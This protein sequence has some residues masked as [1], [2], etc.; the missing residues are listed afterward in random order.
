M[1]ADAPTTDWDVAQTGQPS[2]TVEFT[3]SEATWTTVTVSPDGDSVV[4]DLLGDLYAVP[5]SGGTAELVLGGPAM[6]KMPIFG[7]DRR[8][9]FLSDADGHDNAWACDTDGGNLRQ[10]TREADQGILTEPVWGP[11]GSLVAGRIFPQHRKLFASQIRL[12]EVD[13]GDDGE[14]RVLVDV[15]SSGRDVLE[16]TVSRDGRYVYYTERLTTPRIYVD[17][18]HTN[19]AIRRL[20]LAEGRTDTVVGGFGGAIRPVPSPD[21]RSLAF[22][23]RVKARTVLFRLDLTTGEQRPVFDDLDRD[24][25]AVWE[26]QGNYFPRFSWFPDSRTVAIWCRGGIARIDMHS[27]EKTP[28]PFTARCRHTV[29]DPV[30]PRHELAPAKVHARALRH[31]AFGPGGR[32]AVFVAL[33]RLWHTRLDGGRPRPVGDHGR[34]AA[35]PAYHPDGSEVAYVEWDDERGSRLCRVRAGEWNDISEVTETTAVIRQPAFSPDGRTLAYRIQPHDAHLGGAGLRPGIYLVDLDGGSPTYLSDADDAPVFGPDG[36][37]VYA[38]TTE[39]S[40]DEPS[41]VLFSVDRHGKDRREHARTSSVD[42]Y[43]LRLSPDGRWL[44]FRDQH[45]YHLVPY[46]ETGRPLT[47]SGS[48]TEVPGTLL[49]EHG[50]HGL[51]WSPDGRSLHWAVG[52]RLF[53]LA[54][55]ADGPVDPAA[56]R[57]DEVELTV[58]A[59]APNGRIALVGGRVIS[60]RG[61]EVI[62]RGTV[63]VEN[64]RIAAVGPMHDIAVPADATV[65]D[66]TGK[67]VMPGLVDGHGHIDGAVEDA[68]TPQKQAN[69]YAALAFG[70]TTNFDPFSSELPTFESAET[71]QA[72]LTRG[73]RWIATGSAVHGRPHNFFHLYTPIESYEDALRVVRNKAAL[74]ALSIK[75]YKWPARKHRQMLVKAAREVGV[76]IVVEGETHFYNNISMILDGHT[77]LEHNL[78][79]ATLYDDVVQ[80]MAAAEV[81]NTP[82][83]VVA[84]G[85]LFGENWAYQRGEV[86]K[87][88]RV[89]TY[90]QACLSGYSPLNTPYEAPPHARAMTTIHVDEEIYDIG[91]LSV[92]RSVCRLDE[93]G[94][95]INAGSHGQ[96]PGMAMH[97][98][99]ALLAEGGMPPHRVLRAATANTAES[100]GVGDQIGSLEAGKLADLIVLDANPLEDIRNSA[101]VVMAMVNGRLLDAQTL[102]EIA[103]DPKPRTRFMW[104]LQDT[105]G[106]DWAEPW[107]GGCGCCP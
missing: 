46:R 35:E 97:W 37:R 66:C 81:S 22:L 16:A 90:I 12:Y 106:I 6:H 24:N 77:N 9:L 1:S 14:G 25:Q 30:R 85:E 58:P 36:D 99:M 60:L 3:T 56:A 93:A 49:M 101:R 62:E 88:P 86:W 15:P 92:S 29:V 68:V 103:P 32:E 2:R 34:H 96:M 53:S 76:N 71:T 47:V 4:F 95:R 83:L 19:F 51:S 65:V 67:T 5:A 52:P 27:G 105:S 82:T 61:E 57:E 40:G 54:V 11:S 59:D 28:I 8:L 41:V 48:V 20:D 70:V 91:V 72:G 21:G 10:L 102:D 38:T 84:F 75:S 50:G 64:D 18:N 63:L 94:V 45:R 100:L 26:V 39:H 7:S 78:P 33:G 69:R 104:E 44:A 31:P 107:G 74:G 13:R 80:L 98:E 43:E 42:T 87:D 79:V 73:P 23:R 17:A 55:P 89:R